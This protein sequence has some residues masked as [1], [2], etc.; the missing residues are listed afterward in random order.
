MDA[1]RTTI[2][3]LDDQIERE[4]QRLAKNTQQKRDQVQN[5]LAA[6]QSRVETHEAT[7]TTIQNQRQEYEAKK[8]DA[9]TQGR[10]LEEKQKELHERI[11]QQEQMIKNCEQAEKDNLLPYGRNIKGVLE[12][13]N[14]MRWHGAKPLGPLGAFVKAKDVQAWGDILRNQLGKFLMSFAITDPR[15]KNPLKDLLRQTQK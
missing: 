11:K 9:E 4:T 8:A 13:I 1:F 10:Q 12:Q 14:Q 5:Q 15:D 3:E 2:R 7:L 6:M